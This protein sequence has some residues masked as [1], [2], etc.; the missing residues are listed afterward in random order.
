VEKPSRSLQ[1]DDEES[2]LELL[3]LKELGYCGGDDPLDVFTP[4]IDEW[5]VAE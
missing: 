3:D 1:A 5:Q 2:P 4:F